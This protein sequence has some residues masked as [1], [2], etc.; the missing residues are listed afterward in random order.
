MCLETSVTRPSNQQWSSDVYR[1][2]DVY[3]WYKK[4]DLYNDL[5]RINLKGLAQAKIIKK[6]GDFILDS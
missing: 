6:I 1:W 5:Q 2:Y 3:H 4:D